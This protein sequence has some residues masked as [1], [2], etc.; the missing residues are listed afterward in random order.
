MTAVELRRFERLAD[1][2][3]RGKKT[4]AGLQPAALAAT[5]A[6]SLVAARPDLAR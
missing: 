2:A 6:V 4:S 1:H 3:G 5:S